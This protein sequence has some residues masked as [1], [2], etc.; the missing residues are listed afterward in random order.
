MIL[1]MSTATFTLV[2]VIISLV[3]IGSGLVVA[4]GLW[5][6]QP[7]PLWTALF[8]ASTIATSA[9]GFLFHSKTFGPPHVVGVISL[10]V[11]A[12]GLLALYGLHLAR[13]WRGTY[14]FCALAALYFNVFVAVAQAFD[15]VPALH[16]LAPKGSEPPF[17]VAQL[18]VLG[19]FVAFGVAAAKRFHPLRPAAHA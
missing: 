2:H 11:L 9:T 3:G 5:R 15:K 7:L 10:M 8:L 19:G 12:I 13:N 1:G 4:V 17:A 18:L 6:A 16:A 14:V